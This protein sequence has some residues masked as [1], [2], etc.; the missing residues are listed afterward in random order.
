MFIDIHNHL[1]PGVDDGIRKIEDTILELKLYKEHGISQVIFTP[2]INN[3]SVNTSVEKIRN[4]YDS[5]KNLIES[6]TG[7]IT[8]LASELYLVPNYK[9]FIPFNDSFVLI[10]FP[11]RVYPIY[12]LDAIFNIQLE[13]YEVI[14]VHVERYRWLF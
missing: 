6:E 4:T 1:L 14:L 12:A 9:E 13:G 3:P 8:Y 11:T 10:E 5:L 2:H 7:L